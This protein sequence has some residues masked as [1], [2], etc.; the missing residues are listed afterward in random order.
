MAFIQIIDMR[1]T[2]I[3]ELQQLETEWEAATEGRR[4][5]RRSIIAQDRNDPDRHLIL[6][7]F[8]SYEAAMENSSLP[9]TQAF[10]D[11]QAPLL[12]GAPTFI[13]LDIIE[14]R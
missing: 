2:K 11:K 12:K 9:E 6:A 10:A 4:T 3:E 13:D 14:E 5:L 7:F 8:D 1:T